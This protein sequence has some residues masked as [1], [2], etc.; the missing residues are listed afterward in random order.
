MHLVAAAWSTPRNEDGDVFVMSS[1]ASTLLRLLLASRSIALATAAATAAPRASSSSSSSSWS[2]AAA[3]AAAEA[4]RRAFALAFAPI[5]G[6]R[7][8]P[9]IMPPSATESTT[10]F[11]ASTRSTVQ[12]DRSA[13]AS[14]NVLEEDSSPFSSSSR[15]SSRRRGSSVTRIAHTRESNKDVGV[16][17]LGSAAAVVDPMLTSSSAEA[18]AAASIAA[19]Y[20]AQPFVDAQSRRAVLAFGPPSSTSRSKLGH[21]PHA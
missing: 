10:R 17:S 8:Y 7:V 20:T 5:L 14:A 11:A 16:L 2:V 1:A 13:T 19:P 9:T 6:V 21:A 15:M 4:A 3:E 12:D 18:R